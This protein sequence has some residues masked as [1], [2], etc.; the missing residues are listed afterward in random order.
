VLPAWLVA[1]TVV[2]A[3][4]APAG[5]ERWGGLLMIRAGDN[6]R[7]GAQHPEV[8]L[9][10]GIAVPDPVMSDIGHYF[11]VRESGGSVSEA[12]LLECC[13]QG[14]A[15]YK[16]PRRIEFRSELPL[17]PAGKIHKAALRAERS[18]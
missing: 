5:T 6:A 14:L 10:A 8:M 13:T 12:A 7:L 3:L 9:V 1:I 15:D 11:V 16:V 17:T 18:A 4:L 2:G